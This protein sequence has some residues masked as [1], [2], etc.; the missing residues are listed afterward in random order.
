M[1]CKK[2]VRAIIVFAAAEV[3]LDWIRVLINFAG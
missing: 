3:W 2:L 1:K